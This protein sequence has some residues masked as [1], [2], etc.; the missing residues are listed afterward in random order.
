MNNRE[1]AV[2][3]VEDFEA[4]ANKMQS[5]TIENIVPFIEAA[6][7]EKS[8][9]GNATDGGKPCQQQSESTAPPYS[10]R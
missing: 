2:Q 6:L 7:D 3:V 4:E 9:I 5:L 8:D 1:R 10:A